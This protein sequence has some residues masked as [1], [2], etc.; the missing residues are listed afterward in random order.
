ML[1]SLLPAA[2]GLLWAMAL[3][4]SALAQ[5]AAPSSQLQLQPTD[6]GTALAS[7][8]TRLAASPRDIDAL[9]RAGEASLQLEDP[10][11][12][13][14]FFGRADDVAP[15]NGRVKAGLGRAMLQLDQVGDGLRLMEL[16]GNLG[17]SDFGLLADRGLARDLAAN[18][19]G[20]QADYAA[21]LRLQPND[22]KVI[23]RQAVSYGIAGELDLAEKTIQPLLYKSDRAAWRDKAFILAMNGRT[24]EAVSISNQVMP[25][26]LASA[27]KPYLERMAML[28]PAQRAAAVHLGRFPPGLVNVQVAANTAL[29]P[30]R[31]TQ[32]AMAPPAPVRPAPVVRKPQPQPQSQTLPQT[33]PQPQTQRPAQ[34][35]S[36][37][38]PA[39]APVPTPAPLP[40]TQPR[41]ASATPV[42]PRTITP[43]PRTVQ[44][45]PAP[46][47]PQPV[48]P[49]KPPVAAPPAPA[50]QPGVSPRT[51]ADIMAEIEIP[52]SELQPRVAAVDLSD[53]AM[54]KAARRKAQETAAKKKAEAEAKAKAEADKK[55]LA[56]NP[57]RY[58]VQIG[59]GRNI[60]A[61]GFTLKRMKKE[62]DALAKQDGW[63]AQWGATNRLVVGPFKTLDRAKAVEADLKKAGS[64]AFVWRSEAGE[65]L[66]ALSGK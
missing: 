20:A 51:L 56:A 10:R 6:A 30:P 64:D 38:L 49:P 14:G 31:T 22:Q 43:A 41:G 65:E 45:P 17:Y 52:Q 8:M 47:T 34:T 59:T 50:A 15:D 26:Q 40:S 11:S 33:Q 46:V 7:A 4:G 29:P 27:I 19:T 3:P 48:P 18:Q 61:L 37:P 58:W 23:R 55:R 53:V 35:V 36:A 66:E 54:L 28:N 9:V 42:T 2:T 39:P 32:P 60:S 1:R 21:A 63:S 44:G 16:A 5:S 12:A 57:A 24:S 62:H 25:A 13:L